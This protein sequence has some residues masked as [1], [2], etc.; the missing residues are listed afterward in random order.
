[1]KRLVGGVVFFDD[2]LVVLEGVHLGKIVVAHDLGE[3]RDESLRV[4]AGLHILCRQVHR[5]FDLR[6]RPHHAEVGHLGPIGRRLVV[7]AVPDRVEQL[8][9]GPRG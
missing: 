4:V 8:L 1:M 2:R 9:L 5:L 3:T 7:D 6:H